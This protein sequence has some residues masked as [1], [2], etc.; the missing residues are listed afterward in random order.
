MVTVC[1]AGDELDASELK[2]LFEENR[3]P[4]GGIVLSAYERSIPDNLSESLPSKCINID[5]SAACY[6]GGTTCTECSLKG[7]EAAASNGRGAADPGGSGSQ[8]RDLRAAILQRRAAGVTGV[9]D[10]RD[11][12]VG[13]DGRGRRSSQ[14]QYA[15]KH[16][17]QAEEHSMGNP[18]LASCRLDRKCGRGVPQQLLIRAH[19]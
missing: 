2:S 6:Q 17:M 4:A 9:S 15:W 18:C 3:A 13:A 7:T 8:A 12:Y 1:V 11:S 16:H 14:G 10:N 5:S 19:H